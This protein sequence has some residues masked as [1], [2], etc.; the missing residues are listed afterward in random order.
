MNMKHGGTH[1]KKHDSYNKWVLFF[2]DLEG[3]YETKKERE[4]AR[5]YGNE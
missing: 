1:N 4:R 2:Y 3:K 5:E